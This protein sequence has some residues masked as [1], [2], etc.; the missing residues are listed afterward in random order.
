LR[1]ALSDDSDV[2]DHQDVDLLTLDQLIR[3]LEGLHARKAQFVELRFFSGLTVEQTAKV[4]DVSLG[5]IE[6]DWRFARTWLR[7]QLNRE[8]KPT[9]NGS[10]PLA[11]PVN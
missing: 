8:N 7:Y 5:T 1:V 10:S 3:K 2:V 4:L 9:P 6:R 11:A